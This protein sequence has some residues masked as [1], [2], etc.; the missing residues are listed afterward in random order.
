MEKFVMNIDSQI[1]KKIDEKLT[2][3]TSYIAP[4]WSLKN[5][6]AVNPYFGLAHLPF[7]DANTRILQTTGAFL[8]MDARFYFETFKKNPETRHLAEIARSQIEN[9]DSDQEKNKALQSLADL[10][11]RHSN[12]T[13]NILAVDY[14]SSWCAAYF[15]E[16]QNMLPYPRENRQTL[17]K[18][19]I[20]DIAIYKTL[21]IHGLKNIPDILKK[22]SL[23]YEE[24][25]LFVLGEFRLQDSCEDLYIH[26][27][28]MHYLGWASFIRQRVWTDDMAGINN[29]ELKEFLAVCLVMEYLFF[30][31]IDDPSILREWRENLVKPFEISDPE[32]QLS[33]LHA[34]YEQL[35]QKNVIK[36]INS[37]TASHSESTDTQAVFCIDV[38]SEIFRRNLESVN[39]KISTI[40]FAGFFG[41]P[42]RFQSVL[43]EE[44]PIPH[45]PV[46]IKPTH[47]VVENVGSSEKNKDVMDLIKNLKS[48]K[49]SWVQFKWSS[50]SCFGFVGTLGIF[51]LPI[52]IY[53][54]FLRKPLNGNSILNFSKETTLSIRVSAQNLDE[55]LDLFEQALIAEK[56][57]KG[58]SITHFSKL[59]VIVGHESISQNNPYKSALNCGACGGQSGGKN[60]QIAALIL[61]KTSIRVSLE[62]KGIIIPNDT[63]FVAAVHNTATDEITLYSQDTIPNSHAQLIEKFNEDCEK[64]SILSRLERA[65][66]FNLSPGENIPNEVKNRSVDWS[67]IRPEWGLIACQSFIAAPRD[68]TKGI[69]LHGR[70]F[71]HSYDWKKDQ[72][73]SVLELILTA[74]VVVAS[75]INLQYFASMTSNRVF[76]SGNKTLHNVVSG[77]GVLEGSGGDLKIGLPLQSLHDGK[78]WQ[79]SPERLNVFIAAPK[80]AM[81]QVLGKNELIKNLVKNQWI[82]LFSMSDTGKVTHKI[83]QNGD[84]EP[85]K[86]RMEQR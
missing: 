57:I 40:G 9:E 68:F 5:F 66:R 80:E 75:W 13:W 20:Q 21:R 2:R 65:H 41:I 59:V 86:E 29:T 15:D 62:Q 4:V 1:D 85:V 27:V 10:Y 35:Q 8:H 81:N 18:S 46:L 39:S 30:S 6:V 49:K 52:L 83:N 26:R 51:Y 28:F 72:N 11:S 54:I 60:A 63:F 31:Q 82:H 22:I 74:P 7:S 55:S 79:H 33:D 64:A 24:A 47:T 45:C 12:K 76:G 56:I 36:Q 53:Q 50:V 19:W 61:N 69:P 23:N 71:L 78:E 32:N 17:F 16:G 84:W 73:F 3:L 48:L 77:I 44:G 43:D 34:E 38:R 25:I 58:L 70:S 42:F 37:H 14:V 67:Q